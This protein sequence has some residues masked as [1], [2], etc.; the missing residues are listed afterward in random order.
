MK[1]NPTG[2]QY[3]RLE[4]TWGTSEPAPKQGE[5]SLNSAP[6]L[7]KPASKVSWATS[8]DG[9]HQSSTFREALIEP[10][11]SSS[12]TKKK[13]VHSRIVYFVMVLIGAGQ[14]YPY[15]T[16]ITAADY[17]DSTFPGKNVTYFNTT[18][19]MYPSTL[20]SLIFVKYGHKMSFSLRIIGTF[21]IMGCGL[22]MIP[23]F[24]ELDEPLNLVLVLVTV[25]FCGILQC[26]NQCGIYAFAG[27]LPEQY[28]QGAMVGQAVAGVTVSITRI[29]TKLAFPQTEEGTKQGG[30]IFFI[31]GTV[32]CFACSIGFYLTL[33]GSFSQHHLQKFRESKRDLLLSAEQESINISN[34]TSP[35]VPPTLDLG[36]SPAK[37]S[38]RRFLFK[39]VPPNQ[40]PAS[41]GAVAGGGKPRKLK[42]NYRVINGKIY[43]LGCAVVTVFLVTFLPFPAL[44][45]TLKSKYKFLQHGWFGIFLIT[46]FTI[47]DTIGRYCAGIT[48]AGINQHNI[49]CPLIARMALYPLFMLY[50]LGYFHDEWIVITANAALALS[51]GFL[52]TIAM[53]L[54]P[55]QLKTHEREVGGAMMSFYAQFGILL[56]CASALAVSQILKKFGK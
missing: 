28:T 1:T 20:F 25:G 27:I 10:P 6:N 47:F 14:L 36:S 29:V 21:F 4:G 40:S 34:S 37:F 50:Y 55:A 17:F 5:P 44:C 38:F 43:V 19:L 52:V 48:K 33:R 23:F 15:Q 45:V 18:I 39:H 2:S 53:M 24:S 51:N 35:S 7:S 22:T 16:L 42:T 11:H 32:V 56:G 31:A 3:Q 49:W 8:D 46:E 9:S 54:A 13:E 12:K 26:A 41:R 30:K